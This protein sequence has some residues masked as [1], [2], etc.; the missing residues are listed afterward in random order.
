VYD[1]M[2]PLID[3]YQKNTGVAPSTIPDID[4]SDISEDPVEARRIVDKFKQNLPSYPNKASLMNLREVWEYPPMSTEMAIMGN[5]KTNT[6]EQFV[7]VIKTIAS[8]NTPIGVGVV[9]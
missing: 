9:K 2:R 5:K 1:F 4:L 3:L 8:S 6:K 7:N